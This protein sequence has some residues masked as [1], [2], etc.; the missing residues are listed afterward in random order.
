MNSRNRIAED[1]AIKLQV[2]KIRQFLNKIDGIDIIVDVYE[3]KVT[4]KN[5]YH[6][7]N[8]QNRRNHQNRRD[9]NNRRHRQNR[10]R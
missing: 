1:L 9:R 6:F 7:R 5:R 8:R 2:S 10:H 3:S 4:D